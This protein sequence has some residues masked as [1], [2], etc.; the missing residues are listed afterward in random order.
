MTNRERSAAA[1]LSPARRERYVRPGTSSI[2]RSSSLSSVL[3]R[4]RAADVAVRG[5]LDETDDTPEAM[6]HRVTGEIGFILHAWDWSETSLLLDVLT[7]HYG[8]VFVVAKG[9]RRHYSQFRGLLTAFCPLKFTWSGKKEAKVLSRV[10][11]QGS[12]MPLSSDAMLS[13]FYV[14]ELVLKLTEREDR[15]PGLFTLYVE[16]LH[17]LALG[18]ADRV[19]PAL[20]KFERGILDAAGWSPA[21]TGNETADFFVVREGTITGLNPQEA[22]SDGETLYARAVVDSVVNNEMRAPY[23]R[24]AREI[25][26]ALLDYHLE[27]R[28]IHTRRIL[29]ELRDLRKMPEVQKS[30]VVG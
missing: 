13:A 5:L 3:A 22:P 6:P 4:R 23:L 26:R 19:Q 1:P 25:L 29:N 7:P 21:L 10:E 14:N 18:E 30:A 15:H 11:W 20:R 12:M 27:G 24:E 16:T 9:A 8:R 17:Q 28:E 2:E